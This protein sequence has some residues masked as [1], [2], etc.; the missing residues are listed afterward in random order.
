L[1]LPE[2]EQ[3][4]VGRWNRLVS[5]T[6]WEKGRIIHEWREALIAAGA[7]AADYA[8][9]AWSLRVGGVTGQHV[10]RLRRVFQKFFSSYDK[11]HGLYWSHFQTAI[12]WDDAEMWL[13]GAV[14]N[15]WSVSA[16]RRTRWETLGAVAT[17]Q[18]PDANLVSA[19]TDEDWTPS[20]EESPRHTPDGPA[21]YEEGP[22]P[23]PEGPD[24]GDADEI[25]GPTGG[26]GEAVSSDPDRPTIAPFRPFEDLAELPPDLA[27]AFDAYKLSILRHKTD[28]WRQI[29]RDAVLASLDALKELV[30]AP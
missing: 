12:D 10:G 15:S 9:E 17:E 1:A 7:P 29:G 19:D 26:H 14:Q 24:F 2:I 11:Y 27:D 28:G 5:S 4:F 6:N 3:P 20:Q 25:D 13:E 22:L 23:V 21:H 30:L 18:P 16:M 8:D